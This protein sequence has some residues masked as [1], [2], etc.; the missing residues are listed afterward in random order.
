MKRNILWVW[1]FVFLAV[2]FYLTV[3]NSSLPEHI[4][5]HFDINGKPNGFQDR[6]VFVATFLIFIIVLNGLFLAMS[7][8]IQSFP[9]ALINMPWKKYWFATAE[10]KSEAFERLRMVLGLT[11]IFVCG[12]LLL[13]ENIIDQA[14]RPGAP[15]TSGGFWMVSLFSLLLIGT[16]FIIT[17]PPKEA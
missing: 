17:R 16:I 5:V 9:T 2:L 11:G 4:A 7:F 10:R 3:L 6:S 15:P 14:S 8:L 13:T 1:G 12:M